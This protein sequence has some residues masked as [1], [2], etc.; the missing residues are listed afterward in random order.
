MFQFATRCDAEAITTREIGVVTRAGTASLVDLARCFVAS[1]DGRGEADLGEVAGPRM[2][3]QRRQ[4][5]C[6]EK[7]ERSAI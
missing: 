6:S 1:I 5:P 3:T 7:H 2:M 4:R